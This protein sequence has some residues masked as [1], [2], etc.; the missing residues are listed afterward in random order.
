MSHYAV[1]VILPPD[2]DPA[3]PHNAVAP[4]LAPYD[5][6]RAVDRH[7]EPCGCRRWRAWRRIAE[8][9]AQALGYPDF[10]AWR[11]AMRRQ[12]PPFAWT[13]H[14]VPE[15]RPVLDRI[16]LAATAAAATEAADPDCPDCHGA[17]AYATTANPQGYWDY[18]RCYDDPP[19]RL[20]DYPD[21]RPPL[22]CV[23]PDGAWHAAREVG[24]FGAS[25]ATR[26]Q[27]DWEREWDALRQRYRDHWAVWVDCHI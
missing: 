8:A 18:W 21:P 5:E 25:T 14:Q 13:L 22:A 11:E 12:A 23:T 1:L 4:L 17:G 6:N 10:A 2:A 15:A 19:F 24:W 20:A 3:T 26:P 7:F 27:A 16:D 9:E